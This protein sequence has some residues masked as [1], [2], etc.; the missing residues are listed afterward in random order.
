M[1]ARGAVGG[2]QATETVARP[3]RMG[4][5]RVAPHFDYLQFDITA[6]SHFLNESVAV[7]VVFRH[8]IAEVRFFLK[9]AFHVF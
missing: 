9:F 6:V 7:V 1:R 2:P 3:R 4:V 5:A 8:E